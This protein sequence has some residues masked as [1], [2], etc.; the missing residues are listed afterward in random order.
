MKIKLLILFVIFSSVFVSCE[1]DMKWINPD[2][3]KADQAEIRKICE[4]KNA[5]CGQIEY[6]YFGKMRKVFCGECNNGY[7]CNSNKCQDI[8]ECADPS[9]NNCNNEVSIC[10]NEDGKYSCICKENY[11]GDDCVPDTRLEDCEG[12]PENAAWNHASRIEQTWNGSEWAPSNK[13]FFS[14]EASGSECRFKCLGNYTWNGSQC[15]ADTK[16][17]KCFGLPENARW[18]TAS[19]ITQTWSGSE[20]MP[21]NEGTYNEKS[22]TTECR[23]KCN[24]HYNWDELTS[25]C[26]VETQKADCSSK[27]A[28]S[29]W[30]DNGANGKFTQTWTDSGWG[31]AGYESEYSETA[32]ECKYICDSTHTWEGDSCINQ[33]NSYCP[34]K[35]ANTVWND[36]GA[37]G[38]YT[39]T[40]NSSSGWSSSYSSSYSEAAGICK[41]KC[42]STHTW[43][44]GSCINQ[45]TVSC[46]GLPA[47]HASWNTASSITQTWTSANGWQP[48]NAGVY[49]ETASTEECRFKCNEHYDWK[50]STSTCVAA[51]QTANCDPKPEN[52]V[53]NDNG[54]NGKFTQ[55]WTNSG[56]SPVS[57]AASYSKT[58]GECKYK[59]DSTHTWENSSCINQ[60]NV[61]CPTKPANTVWNDNGANGTYTQ[62]WSSS[63]GW[64][65]S[66]SSSYSTTA[67]ICRYKC[68]STHTWEGGGCINQK[69]SNCGSKPANTVWN[70]NGANGTYTQTWNS[71]S[72]WSSSHSS[73]YGEAAGE[74]V[75]KCDDTHYWDS[76]ECVNPCDYEPCN[77][78]ANAIPNSC[79]A[80]SWQDYTCACESKYAWNG[81][82]CVITL[83][84]ICTGQ[85]KCY[86]YSAATAI[87]CPVSSN[88]EFYG[89]DAQYAATGYC[90]PQSF[91][92]QTISDD[93]VVL[94]NNTGLM[95]QQTIPAETYTWG[96]WGTPQ[97]YCNNLTYAGYSDWRLPT[98]QE[99]L[100]I[101]DNSK[102]YPINT[103]YFPTTSDTGLWSSDIYDVD[104]ISTRHWIMR[105]FGGITTNENNYSSEFYVRCVRGS[106]LPV[107]SFQTSNINGDV[108]VTDTTTGLIWQKTY[109]SKNWVQALSYCENLTYAGYSDWRLPN[110]NEI[111]S[112]VNYEKYNPA[113]D[114]PDMLSNTFWSSSTVLVRDRSAEVVIFTS[115]YVSTNTS[116]KNKCDS[117][118]GYTRCVRSERIN[119]PCENHSCESVDHSSGI[120]IPKNAFEYSC[121]CDDGY[122]WDGTQ[123]INPC[124]P[125]PCNSVFNSNKVCTASSW[126]KYTCGCEDRYFWDG[127]QCINP[128]DSYPCNSV[129]NSNK[130][131]TPINSTKYSCGCEN[132]YYWWGTEIGCTNKPLTLGSICT[133]QDKCY[134]SGTN[135]CP[136]EDE[137]YFG[138]DAQYAFLGVC[139]PQSLTASSDVVVDNNTGLTWEKSPSAES[140]IW[141]NR[142]THC[143]ELNSSNY[144]GKSNW[145]VP[146]PLELLTIVDNSTYNPATNSN[147]T[148]MPTGSNVYLWT[149]NEFKGDTTYFTYGFL[150]SAGSSWYQL[151]KTLTSKVLCV[152]G[153]EMKPAVSSD[154]TTSSDGKTVTD[155]RTGLMWQKEYVIDKT[156]KWALQYCEDLTYAGYSDWRLPNKNELASLVNYEKSDS[157]YSYFPD[158]PNTWLW[159]SST[160]VGNTGLAW[161]VAFSDGSIFVDYYDTPKSKE[162]VVLCVR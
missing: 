91:T 92:V 42:D 150:L 144:G 148:G 161:V 134:N 49:N 146:N 21:S 152:S 122:F 95:W 137:D 159:S 75:Y 112:L 79:S 2:D 19:E 70:D 98:V 118:S 41:Y 53:W 31:P 153:E 26:E 78:I 67:G 73:S 90:Y 123:C 61:N 40:W 136:T 124:D 125:N 94:D 116:S 6:E 38:T 47:E 74:C 5:E 35:P 45:K 51:T 102:I 96:S 34:A 48:S 11:S 158:I 22:S 13:G 128:C 15:V 131:C 101:A 129:S 9:K 85:N 151:Q 4:E 81:S 109:E 147:F 114:F 8:D 135:V 162:R 72:G 111:A 14:E 71:S 89:Q 62:T 7:D 105:G 17:T 68:D 69:T 23:F 155:S 27:P 10:A 86:S 30:N 84:N 50:A 139:I 130:V 33:K 132:G 138:Q 83:G 76:S 156:W 65:A 1:K 56:W 44:G 160:Y 126:N 80:S 58:A 87:S 39:Q 127:T 142:E 32:G 104:G 154:F 115:G 157:P 12:L 64:S 63:S 28:N 110:K 66:Y 93:K 59:C 97:R 25:K 108:V 117:C 103:T 46:T 37:N 3:S 140:Y 77:G 121:E 60:K 143:N 106:T 99:L 145:R 52:T 18:N 20:W 43:E 120:C 119:D 141:D 24:E 36:N 107:A 100:T 133:G 16:N 29:V 88:A 55:T 149:N 57:F 113:S 54:A 82:Q